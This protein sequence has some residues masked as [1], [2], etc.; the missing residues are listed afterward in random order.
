MAET[1]KAVKATGAVKVVEP[2]EI[3][4]GELE[5]KIAKPT[6]NSDKTILVSGNFTEL[7]AN[8]QKVVNK[9]K[10]VVL[11]EDNVD[12]VKTLKKQFVSLRTG[13]EREKKEYKKVY[14]DPAE[15]LLKSMC[16]ELLHIVDEG[17]KALGDQLDEYDQRRKDELTEVLNDY[18]KDAI[19][20]YQLREEYATQIQLKKEYYNKTQK[21]EDSI[22]DINAQA[23]ELS[24]KQ[25]EYDAGVALIQAE[26]EGTGFVPDTYIRELQYKSSMEILLEIKADKKAREEMKTKV[27]AGE[28]VTIGEPLEEELAKAENF[29]SK[30]EKETLRERVLRVRYKPEQAS[31]MAE[32]FKKN[33]IQ[34]EFIK[35]DF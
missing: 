15:N 19:S 10:G 18:V 16:D 5:L 25:K 35:T 31:L 26:C 9:Y 13:I 6:L 24:K 11:T 23:E 21:E 14:I 1:K 8:I 30:E 27:D 32:F 17:E 28:K 33:S 29:N 34:F 20:K 2:K 4:F 7:G 3:D 12:Y 22:D